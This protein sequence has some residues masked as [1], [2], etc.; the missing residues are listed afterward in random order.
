MAAWVA[1]RFGLGTAVAR[2]VV[3]GVAVVLGSPFVIGILGSSANLGRALAARAFP[4]AEPGRLDLAAAP[5]RALIVTIQLAGVAGVGF[6]LAA[7][8]QPVLPAALPISLLAALLVGIGV[9]FWRDARNLSGHTR[10]GAEVIV[11]ALARHTRA[12]ESEEKTLARAYDLLPGLGTPVPVRLDPGSRAI[13]RTI[14]ELELRGRTG[15]T[16]LAIVRGSDVVLVPDGHEPLRAG[17]VVALAG[18]EG[19]VATARAVLL[20]GAAPAS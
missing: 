15:A 10:A 5:R 12:E 2:G 18:T 1:A 19:S 3:T 6:L 9:R 7:V 16:I 14:G 20:D 17:D 13:G 11:A 8:T 4:D